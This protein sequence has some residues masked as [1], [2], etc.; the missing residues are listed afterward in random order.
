MKKQDLRIAFMGTPEFAVPSLEAL[1]D[2]DF[3]I[4]GVITAPDR[5]SGRGRKIT[6]SAVK[7]FALDNKLKIL[8]PIN[9]KEESFIA[10]LK[11]LNCNLQIVVAFRML[12][13]IVWSL[14]ALGTFNLHASLLPQYRGAAPINYAIINGEKITGLTTFFIDNKIDT[15]KIILQEKV[16]IG[17]RDNVGSLHDK[18]KLKG[19]ELILKTLEHILDNKVNAQSQSTL[20]KTNVA[21]KTAPKLNKEDCRI[22]WNNSPISIN[23][24]VRG[25]SPYP[26][27]YSILTSKE[28]IR[29]I[30]KIFKV[31]VNNSLNHDKIIGSINSDGKNYLDVIVRNGAIRISE[32]QLSGKKRMSVTAFLRGF[33]DINDYHFE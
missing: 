8:Q 25:L 17:D 18:M 23:N 11:S 26:G 3:N 4:V 27:A 29:H 14:P 24:F 10:E 9:L 30:V 31:A 33:P 28:G 1:I 32:L 6:V 22:G 13:E 20:I 15:G 19:A 16:D 12:P 5:Q 21:L 2:N 7:Q